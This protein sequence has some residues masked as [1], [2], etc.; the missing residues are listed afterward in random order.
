MLDFKKLD[1]VR[2]ETNQYMAVTEDDVRFLIHHKEEPEHAYLTVGHGGFSKL[3]CRV[4][5]NSS[6]IAMELAV[7][8]EEFLNGVELGGNDEYNRESLIVHGTRADIHQ[9]TE[10]GRTYK[11][12]E[13]PGFDGRLLLASLQIFPEGNENG[14]PLLHG[15]F[16]GIEM[17][18][19]VVHCMAMYLSDPANRPG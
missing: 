15:K 12:L 13:Y 5:V 1:W 3:E 16:K 17:A 6:D 9:R 11:V 8:V 7:T 4:R 10:S 18:K 19:H 2:S 14:K